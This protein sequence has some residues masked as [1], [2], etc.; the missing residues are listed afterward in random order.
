MDDM[1]EGLLKLTNHR[2]HPTNKAYK[3]FY[4]RI[5]EQADFFEND[6]KS[7]DLYYETDIETT[8]RGEL[9]L[10]GIRKSD[11]RIVQ[12]LNN[13]AIG[14]FRTPF[15]E[16]KINQYIVILIGLIIVV[17]T[18]LSYFNNNV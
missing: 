5:K 2:E 11:L 12:E 7:N 3:V 1:D 9:Y 18:L 14:K 4:F 17:F 8:N 13:I 6:L 15:I 16:K 10:F